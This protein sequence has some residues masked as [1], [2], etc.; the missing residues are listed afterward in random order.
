MKTDTKDHPAFC[1]IKGGVLAWL[2]DTVGRT[3]SV[4]FR[5]EGAEYIRDL[6]GRLTYRGG[7]LRV[8]GATGNARFPLAAVVS[9]RLGGEMPGNP[10]R[11]VID[12]RKGLASRPSAP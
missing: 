8:S 5:V 9:A 11:L 2:E 7:L 12:L 3:C 6:H 10:A 1:E 4:R